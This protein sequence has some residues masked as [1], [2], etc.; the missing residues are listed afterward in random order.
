MLLLLELLRVTVLSLGHA[1]KNKDDIKGQLKLCRMRLSYR[2]RQQDKERP[3][4]RRRDPKLAIRT[5]VT[6]LRQRS[7]RGEDDYNHTRV[8]L[9]GRLLVQVRERRDVLEEI[10]TNAVCSRIY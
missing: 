5:I 3:S 10:L 9:L 1:K 7:A 6:A 4:Q 2:Q 8:A